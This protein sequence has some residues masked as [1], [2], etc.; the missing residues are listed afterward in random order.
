M[1]ILQIRKA[2]HPSLTQVKGKI[3][4]NHK[5]MFKEVHNPQSTKNNLI[6]LLHF[7][8]KNA[9]GVNLYDSW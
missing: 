5:E 8:G 2:L 6:V 3:V 4:I 9:L 7:A 1:K